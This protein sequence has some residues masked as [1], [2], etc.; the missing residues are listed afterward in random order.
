MKQ[1]SEPMLRR[2]SAPPPPPPPPV[3]ETEEVTKAREQARLRKQASLGKVNGSGIKVLA[4]TADEAGSSEQRISQLPHPAVDE[5]WSLKEEAIRV[6]RLADRD[7]NG[8]L[9]LNE[10][11]NTL[12]KPQFAETALKN[13][14]ENS[15]GVVSLREWLIATK[16][17]FDLSE[18]ACKT[19]LKASEKA[20]LEA[21]A[22]KY[23]MREE[24]EEGEEE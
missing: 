1:S 16:K 19:S 17:T 12:K 24:D 3:Q 14:D 20:I 10:I 18:A 7:G 4:S 23:S 6:F 21:T 11:A 13:Y 9:D 15:D 22:I 8:V 5:E 2:E